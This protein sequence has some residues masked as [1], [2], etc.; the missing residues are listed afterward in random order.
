M[1]KQVAIEISSNCGGLKARYFPSS[2]GS[3]G[4]ISISH[5]ENIPLPELMEFKIDE[6][7][8]PV[9]IRLLDSLQK[10]IS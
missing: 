3:F 1:N 8:L 5:N 7:Y 9:L 10:A 2:D 4:S 6:T